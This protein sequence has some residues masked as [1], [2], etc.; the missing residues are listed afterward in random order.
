M[1]GYIYIHTPDI[2]QI[3][4]KL[5]A[6]PPLWWICLNLDGLNGRLSRPPL[7]PGESARC[8]STRP[9]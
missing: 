6:P 5:N 1:D 8:R 3:G 9:A 4:Q 2:H 7:N